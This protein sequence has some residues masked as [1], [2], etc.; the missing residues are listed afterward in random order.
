MSRSFFCATRR[1]VAAL[2]VAT[3]ALL[4]TSSVAT[5]SPDQRGFQIPISSITTEALDDL[6]NNWKANV[7]RVQIANDYE[8]NGAT[9]SQYVTII[10]NI[11]DN[12]DSKLPLLEA[13]GLKVII[14]LSSPPGGLE[15]HEAPSHLK[16]FSQPALQDEYVTMWRRIANRYASNPTI[17]AFDLLN[18]PAVRKS[19]LNPS[20]KNWTELSIQTV[21]A[22][23]EYA[24]T[25]LV[26]L[27]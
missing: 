26:I 13:R 18:E 19:L 1:C 7:L 3:T 6:V 25:K 5:A 27:K 9:G 12:L 21:A 8:V 10:T 23:R 2:C 20:A 17:A 22:V 11:L 4:L 24:P 14:C 16:M 15:T